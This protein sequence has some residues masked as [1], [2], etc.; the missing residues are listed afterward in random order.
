[1]AT[2]DI[3]ELPRSLHHPSIML[4]EVSKSGVRI[5][6]PAE[7]ST[8]S[9]MFAALPKSGSVNTP[10]GNREIIGIGAGRSRS[11]N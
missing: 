8:P 6:V 9:P 3:H 10:A 7:S 5:E 2:A 11:S 1:M 4:G